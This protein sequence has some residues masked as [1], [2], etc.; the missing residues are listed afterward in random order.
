MLD[1]SAI[2]L[3]I[4]GGVDVDDCPSREEDVKVRAAAVEAV[5]RTR[6]QQMNDSHGLLTDASLTPPLLPLT[7]R[8][9]SNS[10]KRGSKVHRHVDDSFLSHY[11]VGDA[12]GRF[13]HDNLDDMSFGASPIQHQF[14]DAR[15]NSYDLANCCITFVSYE[16]IAR[17]G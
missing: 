15:L 9:A 14:S 3:S 1:E 12:G 8:C 11:D 4:D 10:G 17:G 16:L 7:K 5:E 6:F 13:P 2:L